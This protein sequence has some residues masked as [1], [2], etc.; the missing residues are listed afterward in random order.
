MQNFLDIFFPLSLPLTGQSLSPDEPQVLMLWGT[1]DQVV[2]EAGHE[3]LM[4]STQSEHS[5]FVAGREVRV[6][7]SPG[8]WRGRSPALSSLG[9]WVRFALSSRETETNNS[10]SVQST[11]IH[12][13]D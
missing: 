6:V 10:K 1:G 3:L 5:Q 9:S 8:R 11:Q 7:G 2:T 4:A 12:H 13:L